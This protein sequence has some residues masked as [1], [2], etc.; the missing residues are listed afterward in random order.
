MSGNM[1]IA[2]AGNNRIRRVDALT[3]IIS[4]LVS[5]GS[6]L[7]APSQVLVDPEGLLFILTQGQSSSLT[8]RAAQVV[9]LDISTGLST[10]YAG[11]GTTRTPNPGTPA[12][13]ASLNSPKGVASDLA[14][15]I[16][17]ADSLNNQILKIDS[18]GLVSAVLATGFEPGGLYFQGGTLYV[19]ASAG[20]VWAMSEA[21]GEFALVAGG[22]LGPGYGGDG[23]LALSAKLNNPT[24]IAA[25]SNGTLYISDSG[26]NRVRRVSP[27]D[28]GKVNGASGEEIQT[29]AGD[30]SRVPSDLGDGGPANAALLSGVRGTAQGQGGSVYVADTAN[31]RI[32]RVDKDGQISTFAGG[33]PPSASCQGQQLNCGDRGPARLAELSRPTAVAV[34]AA[35]NLYISDT[36][37]HRV[38]QVDRAGVIRRVAGGC[39]IVNGNPAAYAGDGG[40][41]VD[42]MMSGPSGLTFDASGNLFI[43]DSGNNVIRRVTPGA[44]GVVTGAPDETITTV[45]GGGS[46]FAVPG[47]A[48]NTTL[49]DPEGVASGPSGVLFIA[50]TG[51]HRILKLSRGANG[52]ISGVNDSTVAPIAGSGKAGFSGD[53]GAATGAVVNAPA[54]ITVDAA[55]NLLVADTGNGRIRLIDKA[56]LIVTVAGGGASLNDGGP[57]TGARLS[58]PYS[59]SVGPD[60]SLFI[61]DAGHSRVRKVQSGGSSGPGLGSADLAVAIVGA[62]QVV[63]VGSTLTYF[64]AI[65]NHGP[66]AAAD[67]VLAD[68]LSSSVRYSS[69]TPSS[70][71]CTGPSAH[72]GGLVTCRLGT[73]A[74]NGVV[75][76]S[77]SVIPEQPGTVT[78]QASARAETGDPDLSNNDASA[79]N[80]VVKPAVPGLS[81]DLSIT[82]STNP[83]DS[84]PAGSDLVYTLTVRNAGP[85]AAGGVEFTDLLPSQSLYKSSKASQGTCGP[86]VTQ[87][88]ILQSGGVVGCALGEVKQG[89]SASV[90]IVVSTRAG[91]LSNQAHV[92]GDSFDS[93]LSNNTVTSTNSSVGSLADLRLT[94][95]TLYSEVPVSMDVDFRLDVFN[96]GPDSAAQVDLESEFQEPFVYKSVTSTQGSCERTSPTHIKCRLGDLPMGPGPIITLTGTAGDNGPNQICSALVSPAIDPDYQNNNSCGRVTA[97]GG[98]ADLSLKASATPDPVEAGDT[99]VY[100]CEVRDD[101]PYTALASTITLTLPPW[102]VYKTSAGGSSSGGVDNCRP[103]AGNQVSCNL[104]GIGKQQNR[105]MEITLTH[106]RAGQDSIT[107]LLSSDQTTPDPSTSNNSA[108][109][110]TSVTKWA[111]Y[112]PGAG[113]DAGRSGYQPVTPG[114]NSVGLVFHSTGPGDREIVTSP[115]TTSGLASRRLVAY[116]TANGNVHLRKVS[117]GSEV[118]PN[119][120]VHL[121]DAPNPFGA[122]SGGAAFVDAPETNGGAGQIYALHNDDAGVSLAQL[123]GRTGRLVRKTRIAEAA[124]SKVDSSPLLITQSPTSSLLFFVASNGEGIESLFRIPIGN[125]SSTD[126][127]LGQTFTTGDVNANPS[128]GPTLIYPGT[129]T[130]VPSPASV[131]IGTL[132]GR[133]RTFLAS[134]PASEGPSATVGGP[135]DEV[136]TPSVPRSDSG[137]TPGEQT[138]GA[139]ASPVIYVASTSDAPDGSRQTTVHSIQSIRAIG[140]GPAFAV[141][142]SAPLPGKAAPALAL[143]QEGLSQF[144]QLPQPGH[145]FLSTTKGLFA[146]NT[147]LST[148]ASRLAINGDGFG[149]TSPAAGDGFI[150]VATDSGRQLIL[151][152]GTLSPIDQSQFTEYGANNASR[153]SVGQPALAAGTVQFTSDRGIFSYHFATPASLGQSAPALVTPRAPS[154][155]VSGPGSDFDS[156]PEPREELGAIFHLDRKSAASPKS[157]R[158]DGSPAAG[159]SSLSHDLVPPQSG[160][161]VLPRSDPTSRRDSA[162]TQ[163]GKNLVR[164]VADS[165]RQIPTAALLIVA[166]LIILA[167]AREVLPDSWLSQLTERKGNLRW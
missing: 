43:A 132:D 84:L 116:G 101:G 93:D 64:V 6:T 37:H 11:G 55:G 72:Q 41:A 46:I 129:G 23:G 59:V 117:D 44:D 49:T 106:Y 158:E 22:S 154:D 48:L 139:K 65:T 34:D 2:D 107:M 102:V 70:G 165:R 1:Y 89:A 3:G 135:S 164:Y 71:E 85:D 40:A 119:G 29:I 103:A 147:D 126:S 155:T 58:N 52:S 51:G 92:A 18:N 113:L 14:G 5:N 60:A 144:P 104:G 130:D 35:G 28:D 17:I 124:R 112:W 120:G 145:I 66:E 118:G 13:T 68:S 141:K 77:I 26:N 38:R 15:N 30:G 75:R 39:C 99:V 56:G 109:V 127:A 166:I 21:T 153:R 42:A 96:A 98:A 7:F 134:D 114:S 136:M 137:A 88:P 47:S 163:T 33:G 57:A 9:K 160:L 87:D 143:D 159:Q 50:D 80:K 74:A 94:T 90:T 62:P 16:Y 20:N 157:S 128:A 73:I 97:S 12:T 53:G 63:S 100:H 122:P 152:S 25:D 61:A 125:P 142:D 82:G 91:Q 95:T 86:A 105:A 4:T 110:E 138:S 111:R 24:D 36:G 69:A 123:D 54:G 10:P 31:N 161:I 146:L 32:R 150:F 19:A 83:V 149:L 79:N 151:N 45:A 140:A 108:T 81:S 167:L 67:S 115:I 8:A 162:P 121:S 76:V 148:F 131:A 133:V 156:D 27:G 78:N